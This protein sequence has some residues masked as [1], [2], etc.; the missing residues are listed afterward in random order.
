MPKM[1]QETNVSLKTSM[2]AS[3][4]GTDPDMSLMERFYIW[5][6]KFFP[7]PPHPFNNKLQNERLNYS[8]FEYDSAP[9][10]FCLYRG[11]LRPDFYTDKKIIDIA[12]GGGG[13]SVYLLEMGAR[14]MTGVDALPLFI[15]QAQKFAQSKGLDSVS[16]FIVA[17]SAALPFS[18]SSFDL[19]IINDAMEHVNDP[20]KT[21]EEA[22]RVV[23]PGGYVLINF[24]PYYHPRGG[25]VSDVVG[26]PWE[27]VLFSEKTR[28]KSYRYLV[29]G[30]HDEKDRIS[31]RIGTKNGREAFTY[32]NH[33]TIRQF[34]KH[35]RKLQKE[36]AIASF[37]LLSFQKPILNKLA[38]VSF[39]NEFFTKSVVCVL[40]RKDK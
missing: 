11:I 39:V 17:D 35:L 31:Y 40:R 27:H 33:L 2:D 29:R 19:A 6:N 5:L 7:I 30:L 13:K 16:K 21:L 22:S 28:I 4:A 8:Q 26:I 36:L 12:C 20:Y 9:S 24:E 1:P 38:H 34:I 32:I 23:R 14:D 25:H 18:D 3:G 10:V 15:E 37:E